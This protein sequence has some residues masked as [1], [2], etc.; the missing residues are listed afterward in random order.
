M[1]EINVLKISHRK[2]A[3]P[4]FNYEW[5]YTRTFSSIVTSCFLIEG[6]QEDLYYNS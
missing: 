1:N 6:I 5:S 4:R 3:A 2:I